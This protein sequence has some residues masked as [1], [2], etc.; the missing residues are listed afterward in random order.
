MSKIL[1]KEFR[2]ELYKN[3]CEAGYGKQEAQKIVSVKYRDALKGKL[4]ETLHGQIDSIEEGK[5]ELVINAEELANGLSE[6][7]KLNEFFK[8]LEKSS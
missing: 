8:K 4:M 2:N 7:T 1:E 3:L 5:N 6:L